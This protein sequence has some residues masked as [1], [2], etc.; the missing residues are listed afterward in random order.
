[1][2]IVGPLLKGTPSAI[3]FGLLYV[4]LVLPMNTRVERVVDVMN[5]EVLPV[6]NELKKGTPMPNVDIKPLAEDISR[7]I[8]ALEDQGQR[9]KV[10]QAGLERVVRNQEASAKDAQ[11]IRATLAANQQAARALSAKLET[12][13]DE[14]RAMALL[15]SVP[16]AL[17]RARAFKAGDVIPNPWVEAGEFV[18]TD[19]QALNAAKGL[20]I[21][22]YSE[23]LGLKP[24]ASPR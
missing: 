4:G 1:M 12:G 24:I 8:A 3:V 11:E 14:T 23:K 13:I 7:A 2:D 22:A 5:R 19:P 9:V 20:T 15:S 16:G 18:V 21:K 6:I 10:M 17:G